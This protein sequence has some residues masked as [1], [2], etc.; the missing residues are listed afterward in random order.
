MKRKGLLLTSGCKE[1]RFDNLIARNQLPFPNPESRW[2]DYTLD[3]AFRLHLFLTILD[4]A[5]AGIELAN[6]LVG[7]GLMHFA[8]HPLNHPVQGP[9]VW[10][11][12]GMVPEPDPAIE[13]SHWKFHVAGS[14][15]DMSA[16]VRDQVERHWQ[17]RS[18]SALVCA[19]VSASARAVRQAALEIGLPEG[20]D[21]SPVGKN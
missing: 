4:Q 1:A 16:K 20:V 7:N 9:E 21:F 13:Q 17:G 10:I 15:E 18:V 14:L 2:S 8:T 5:G 12:A 6:Y 19:N 11:A 3:E